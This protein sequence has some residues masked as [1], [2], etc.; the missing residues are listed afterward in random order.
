[1]V[2]MPLYKDLEGEAGK[3]WL[4]IEAVGTVDGDGIDRE[5]LQ[6]FSE[7]ALGWS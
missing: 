5:N 7:T 2:F 6:S 3:V 1:M 4:T